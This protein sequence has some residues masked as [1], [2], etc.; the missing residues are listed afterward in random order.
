VSPLFAS[1][2]NRYTLRLGGWQAWLCA[3]DKDYP[4]PFDLSK[5]FP[6][7]AGIRSSKAD[8]EWHQCPPI[9]GGT[10][11]PPFPPPDRFPSR[12]ANDCSPR[13]PKVGYAGTATAQGAARRRR[14]VGARALDLSGALSFFCPRPLQPLP[15]ESFAPRPSS[16]A[17]RASAPAR[18]APPGRAAPRQHGPEH[19]PRQTVFAGEGP[20]TSAK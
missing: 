5:A 8:R 6:G 3:C 1:A 17:P 13:F 4:R 20:A 9:G 10:N 14:N 19:W 16:R 7:N 15:G 11:A 2:R 12:E 18:T